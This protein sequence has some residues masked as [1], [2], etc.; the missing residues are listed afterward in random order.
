MKNVKIR[1]L[2]FSIH[3]AE[4][5]CI[6]TVNSIWYRLFLQ[7]YHVASSIGSQCTMQSTILN[8]NPAVSSPVSNSY[9]IEF[10]K[11]CTQTSP[12]N[13]FWRIWTVTFLNH[14]FGVDLSHVKSSLS[15]IVVIAYFISIPWFSFSLL[16]AIL[17]LIL[18]DPNG[19]SRWPQPH[20]Q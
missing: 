5:I 6:S 20:T 8:K 4:I 1:S 19:Q 3:Q 18:T 12:E 15:I 2:G 14:L 11:P 10:L 16:L 17:G 13:Y 7:N 9:Y